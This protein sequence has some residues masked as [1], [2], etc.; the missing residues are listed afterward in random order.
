ML[1]RINSPFDIMKLRFPRALIH[2]PDRFAFRRKGDRDGIVEAAPAQALDLGAVRLR[3][4]DARGKA[5][6]TLTV[7]RR[8]LV[9][10]PAVS[11]VEAAVGTEK[12]PVDVTAVAVE[13]EAAQQLFTPARLAG[14][15]VFKAPP[16]RVRGRVQGAIVPQR[17]LR[18]H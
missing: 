5:L 18:K 10:V 4:P 12:R 6:Q 11:P 8:D 3:A 17:A 2:G 15:G 13:L 7:P 1:H 14:P 9:A 16:A